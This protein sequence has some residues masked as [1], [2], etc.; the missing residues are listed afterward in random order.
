MKI[1]KRVLGV[2]LLAVILI[3]TLVAC[4]GGGSETPK[5]STDDAMPSI[6]GKWSDN[7]DETG[8][9][10][11]KNDGTYLYTWDDPDGL[12]LSWT[13]TYETK[14]GGI[15]VMTD[16]DYP[17]VED[18]SNYSIKGDIL[19]LNSMLMGDYTRMK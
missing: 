14:T 11:F 6:L 5:S 2:L 19:E 16:G 18:T 9:L 15:I 12:E 7:V 17:D 3:V 1:T 4:S 8:V 10:E 13:G